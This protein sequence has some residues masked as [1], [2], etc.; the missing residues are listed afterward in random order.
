MMSSYTEIPSR[1]LALNWLWL[2]LTELLLILSRQVQKRILW[3][4][5]GPG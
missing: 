3:M 5:C 2:L 4:H 1:C